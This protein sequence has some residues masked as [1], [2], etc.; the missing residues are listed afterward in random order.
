MQKPR[1]RRSPR[2]VARD[3]RRA[4]GHQWCELLRES[5]DVSTVGRTH[6]HAENDFRT[7][8]HGSNHARDAIARAQAFD[9]AMGEFYT[10]VPQAS[11]NICPA[12]GDFFSASGP[13]STSIPLEA[14][15]SR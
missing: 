13:I 6:G 15:P 4:G 11:S 9:S 1:E 10:C 14:K 5:F 2:C 3:A 8:C 7:R 12:N